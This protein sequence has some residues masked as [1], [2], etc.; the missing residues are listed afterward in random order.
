M[1]KSTEIQILREAAE[2]LGPNSYCGP[3][4]LSVLGEV[5]QEI[6]ADFMPSPSIARALKESEDVRNAARH[7]ADGILRGARKVAEDIRADKVRKVNADIDKLV[8]ALQTHK[9]VSSPA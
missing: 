5:E 2:K 8:H 1:N 6:R 9:F 3:W 7:E 4:L